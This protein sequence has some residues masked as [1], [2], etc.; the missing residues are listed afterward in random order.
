MVAPRVA[1]R[2]R[3]LLLTNPA[4]GWLR[5]ANNGSGR[6]STAITAAAVAILIVGGSSATLPRVVVGRFVELYAIFAAFSLVGGAL[7]ARRGVLGTETV[8]SP[9]QRVARALDAERRAR[10]DLLDE[11]YTRH[12]VFPTLLERDFNLPPIDEL[13]GEVHR[14]ADAQ[15][16]HRLGEARLA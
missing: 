14:I 12:G 15:R 1:L 3:S 5:S 2:I 9:E 13:F 16:R 6:T 11:A 10:D 4:L 8:D 7:Y